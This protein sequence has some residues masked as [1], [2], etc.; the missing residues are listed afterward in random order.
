M[1]PIIRQPRTFAVRVPIGNCNPN[2]KPTKATP[3]RAADPTAPPTAT[4]TNDKSDGCIIMI[5]DV[6]KM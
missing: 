2:R 5:C 1:K 6:D 3:Y 4:R